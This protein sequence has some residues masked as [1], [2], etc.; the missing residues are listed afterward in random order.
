[1]ATKSFGKPIIGIKSSGMNLI[2]KAVQDAVVE[3]VD[4][5]NTKSIIDTIISSLSKN[6]NVP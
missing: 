3:I 2:P 6:K 1:M 5:R 4:M